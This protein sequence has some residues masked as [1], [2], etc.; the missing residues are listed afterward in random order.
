[1]DVG[2][3]CSAE[4]ELAVMKS[5]STQEVDEPRK[6][7]YTL[8]RHFHKDYP[9]VVGGKDIYLFTND[10]RE[11]LDAT[12]GVGVSCLGHGN[13]F[14][15]KAIEQQLDSGLPYL[16]SCFFSNP[17]VD[18]LCEELIKGTGGL[19]SKVYLTGSGLYLSV[20]QGNQAY[21]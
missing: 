3:A 16:A 2:P 11:I 14:V 15:I 21:N 9:K 18:D 13:S 6:P 4:E 8:G 1:M 10:G 17:L 19:M 7:T 5:A 20:R 12:S